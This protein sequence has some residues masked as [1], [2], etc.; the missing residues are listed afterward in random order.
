MILLPLS[1]DGC[2]SNNQAK[3][4]KKKPPGTVE[5]IVSS[6][7]LTRQFEKQYANLFILHHFKLCVCLESLQKLGFA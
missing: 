3:M 5:F 2:K 6:P 4:E 1:G 7:T